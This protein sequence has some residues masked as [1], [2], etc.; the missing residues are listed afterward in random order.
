MGRVNPCKGLDK[1]TKKYKRCVKKRDKVAVKKGAGDY[2]E[3]VIKV[4]KID[5]AV[6]WLLGEDCG[7][8][9]RKKWLNENVPLFKKRRGNCLLEWE[10]DVLKQY[11]SDGRTPKVWSREM[12]LELIPIYNRV[13]N[14]EYDTNTSCQDCVRR[15]NDNFKALFNNYLKQ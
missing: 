6:K 4:L 14:V 1:R 10:Y 5:K 9:E 8:D 12:K 3:D 7:C 15:M 2:V 11:Y 13:F